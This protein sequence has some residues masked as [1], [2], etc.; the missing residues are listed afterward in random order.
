[1][2]G[3]GGGL[4]GKGGP[5]HDEFAIQPLELPHARVDSACRFTTCVLGK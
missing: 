2:L 1:M 5:H 4:R 3:I